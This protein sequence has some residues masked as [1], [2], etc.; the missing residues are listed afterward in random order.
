MD[1]PEQLP[2]G[3]TSEEIDLEAWEHREVYAR[4]GVAIY[5]CQV[6]EHTLVNYLVLLTVVRNGRPVT[7]AEIDS[8][9][10]R[11]FGRTLGQNIRELQQI[12]A[13]DK[14]LADEL[15]PVLT[16]RNSLV[17]RWMSD[18]ALE[19][20]THVKRARMER[21]LIAATDQLT[22]ANERLTALT[23]SL[24]DRIGLSPHVRAEYEELIRL[25]AS[26]DDHEVV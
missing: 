23:M 21:E 18:R 24:N 14:S 20:G 10:E 26:D 19:W 5:F 17:H 22:E 15:A 25:A 16:L 9:F 8:L 11:V 12:L 1:L 7:T 6:L 3:R 13:N 2:D 4:F